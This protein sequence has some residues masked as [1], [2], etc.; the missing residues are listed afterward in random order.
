MLDLD[1]DCAETVLERTSKK[2][3]I[4]EIILRNFAR[5]NKAIDIVD[6]IYAIAENAECYRL[7]YENPD[8]TA[9]LLI[10]NFHRK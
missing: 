1:L 8:K 10:K 5:Q 7:C 6:R 3:V 4:K 9:K 2:E